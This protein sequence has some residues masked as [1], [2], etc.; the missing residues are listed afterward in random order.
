MNFIKK[1]FD[2]R[3]DEGVHLQ[4]QK[5]SRGEFR[6]RAIIQVKAIAGKYKINTS[7]EFA[8]ELVKIVADKLGDE[9]TKITGAIVS[10][11]DLKGELEFKDIKQFQGVKRY[12]I[13]GEMAGSD[14]AKLIDG[15]PKC[16]FA[17]SFSC[18]DEVLKIKAKAPKSGKPGKGDEEPKADFCKLITRDKKVADSFIFERSNFKTASIKHTFMIESIVVPSELKN[19]KDFAIVR[20]KSR[21][22]GRIIR[23][24][25][26]DGESLKEEREFEA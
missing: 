14:I 8:N 24:A 1:V 5:F 23:E 6:N 15:F 21:R 22:K 17:L 25:L 18:G 9:K 10:T 2:K 20:E 7:A 11:S 3:V 13:D 4:F 12:L 16:F 26:I 19:E